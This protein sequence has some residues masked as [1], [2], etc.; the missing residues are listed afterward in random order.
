MRQ[1]GLLYHAGTNDRF[2]C[3][4][5]CRIFGTVDAYHTVFCDTCGQ[6]V[7]NV[8]ALRLSIIAESS[9]GLYV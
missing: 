6:V 2:S 5:G 3:L 4:C 7:M 9:K 1:Y 8:G